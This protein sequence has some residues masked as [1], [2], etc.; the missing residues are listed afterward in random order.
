MLT[1]KIISQIKAY[2]SDNYTMHSA[3]CFIGEDYLVRFQ[4]KKTGEL[5]SYIKEQ[6]AIDLMDAYGI[7]FREALSAVEIW[8]KD[9]HG[10]SERP[11]TNEELE[12]VLDSI[13]RGNINIHENMNIR[14]IIREELTKTDKAEVEKIARKEIE[15]TLKD[16]SLEK[17]VQ[18]IVKNMV[19]GDKDLEDKVVEIS[20]NVLVQLYK[21]LWTK[22][23]FWK[24]S[25]KNKPN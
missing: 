9:V 21:T 16:K 17:R 24:S 7:T 11:L 10:K 8:M 15:D 23:N 6:V 18:D 4:F 19:K 1:P 3:G 20:S 5:Q 22:K 25:L 2:L 14:R 13:K 12:I